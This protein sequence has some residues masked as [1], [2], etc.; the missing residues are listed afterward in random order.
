MR[1]L[2]PP[3]GCPHGDL[4]A[5]RLPIP[6]HPLAAGNGSDRSRESFIIR[7]ALRARSRR[8]RKRMILDVD[9]P[10][11]SKAPSHARRVV[12]QLRDEIDPD[13]RHDAMLLVSELI[14][15]S[16]KCGD[17]GALRLQVDATGPR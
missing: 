2:E 15:S 17:E 3:R 16:V 14:T 6:P 13:L 5:A 12:E 4:N 1:G 10:R 11:D 7:R 9:I 8:R